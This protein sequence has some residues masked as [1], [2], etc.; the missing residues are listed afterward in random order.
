MA[1]NTIKDLRDHLFETIER[2]KDEESPMEVDRAKAICEVSQAIIN[3]AKV[4]IDLMR[5]ASATRPASQ[6][7]FNMPKE[8]RML[9]PTNNQPLKGNQ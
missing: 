7:F 9:P 1:R 2:L 6:E 5:A 8:E 4:E 3:S